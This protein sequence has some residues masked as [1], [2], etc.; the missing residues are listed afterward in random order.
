MKKIILSVAIL[1]LLFLSLSGYAQQLPPNFDQMRQSP[2]MQQTMKTA[3][4]AGIRS[5]WDGRGANLMAFGLVNDPDIRTAWDVSDEQ[6]QEIQGI[7]MRLGAEV[8]NHPEFQKIM[9][10][11]QALDGGPGALFGQNVDEKTQQKLQAIQGRMMTLSMDI[12]TDAIGNVITPEQQEKMNVTLLANM[13]EMPIASSSM[14]E[15]LDL[16]DAQKE[17]MADIKKELEPEFEENLDSFAD[18]SILLAN[19]MFDELEKQGD[20]VFAG[21]QAGQGDPQAMHEKI[22]AMQEKMQAVQKKLME[23]PE[24]KRIS[25]KIH[26][27]GVQFTE[28]FNTK[29]FDVLTDEQWKRL[30]DLIDNPPEYAKIFAKKLKEQRGESEQAGA[31][32]PGPNSWRPGDA[33]PEQYRQ[34]RNT[35]ERSPRE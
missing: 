25:E 31:W 22:K 20:D 24:F 29:M 32:Q 12:M 7:P 8:Q 18:S 1:C 9:E 30:Q 21:M 33:I 27:T 16:T 6:Y 4:K 23:D 13:A 17:Q 26:S 2:M 34:E 5:F 14:Y 35:R 19:M 10:E 3:A 11:V 15:T 28:Q